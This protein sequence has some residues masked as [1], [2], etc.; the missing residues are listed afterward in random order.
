MTYLILFTA[1]DDIN[2]NAECAFFNAEL[3][4]SLM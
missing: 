1:Q 2:L 4:L 3:W